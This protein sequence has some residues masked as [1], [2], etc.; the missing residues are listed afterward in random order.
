MPA[1][2]TH[3]LDFAVARTR[4]NADRLTAFPHTTRAGEWLQSAHGRWT[5][6]FWAGLLWMNHLVTRESRCAERAAAWTRRLEPRA[7]DTSTHDMGFLFEPSCVRAWAITGEPR[8][9]ETA[10]TAAASLCTRYRPLGQYIRAWDDDRDGRT[11]VDTVMNLSLLHW[12]H[13]GEI[14]AA[15]ADTALRE[16]VRPDGSTYHVVDFDPATGTVE[17]RGTHQ[18]WSDTSCWSRGQA[19]ALYGFCRVYHW[20][21]E[22]RFLDAAR[23]L[24]DYFVRRLPSDRLPPWDFDAPAGGPRDTAAAAIAASGLLELDRMDRGGHGRRAS[25][26]GGPDANVG[27]YRAAALELLT[28]LS[29]CLA[30][31]GSQGILLRGAADVPRASAVGESLIYGDHYFVEALL[32]AR[33]PELWE[34]LVCSSPA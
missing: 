11:I 33:R 3:A 8:Y 6:G 28:A 14:A 1:G 26:A 4:E 25:H 10:L 27:G 18:G 32:K 7:R 17:R 5:A 22:A 9:R 19:W 30:E 15:V 2:L 20:T 13:R 12:A 29:G 24:A 34:V 16:H 31:S 23:R 21:R